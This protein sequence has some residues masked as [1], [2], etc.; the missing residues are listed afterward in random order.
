VKESFLIGEYVPH[1]KNSQKQRKDNLAI[2]VAM[3][4]IGNLPVTKQSEANVVRISLRATDHTSIFRRCK[5][6]DVKIYVGA[7]TLSL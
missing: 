2:L 6:R 4:G 5:G 7:F 1:T 3:A